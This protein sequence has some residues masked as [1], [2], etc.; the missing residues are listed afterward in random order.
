MSSTIPDLSAYLYTHQQLQEAIQGLNDGQLSWKPASDKWSVTEVLSHLAD[1]NIV[2]SFRIRAIIS[3]ASAQLPAFDQDPWVSSAKA[4]EGLASDILVLFHSLLVYNHA[5]FER[6][7]A[8]DWDKTGVNFKGQTLTLR[9]VVQSFVA[10]VQ[11]HLGQ[12][13]RIKQAL[14]ARV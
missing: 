8:E 3:G 9:D 4:N 6:L 7:S 2:V 1:H 12:I 13:A 5:L 10:H 14:E 11:N